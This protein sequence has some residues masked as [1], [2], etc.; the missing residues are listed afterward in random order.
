MP[1]R[2]ALLASAAVTPLLVV[3]PAKAQ[4]ATPTADPTAIESERDVVYGEVDGEALLMD[5]HRPPA[6]ENPRAAVILIHGGGW[7]RGYGSRFD[8]D[9]PAKELANAGYVTFN[10]DYRLLTGE[11]GVNQWPVQLDDVQRAVR[12]IRANAVAYNVDSERI[13]S[14]GH[15]SGGH[16]A[17]FLGVRETRD[18]V[19]PAL[20][21]FS[22]RVTCVVDLAGDMDL[23]IPYPQEMDRQIAVNLLGGTA[24]EVPDA[25]QDASPITWVDADSAPFVI[26]H[27]ARDDINPVEHSRTMEVALHEAGVE[28]VYFEDPDADH[29]AWGSWTNSGPW[30]LT[31]LEHHLHPER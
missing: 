16:L 24:E 15:S 2:R 27:G 19:D 9:A 18:N 14:Y 12:W 11:P 22:S 23:T 4:D 17:A 5:I 1:T 31:F 3:A 25:Y 28:V 29:F 20:A 7:T 8:M 26:M 10:I 6:R 13:G 30:T 21:T